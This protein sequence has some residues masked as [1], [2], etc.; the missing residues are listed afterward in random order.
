MINQA[1]YQELAE[2]GHFSPDRVAD[3]IAVYALYGD[4]IR[5]EFTK[6]QHLWNAHRIRP[7]KNRPYLV[8]GKPSAIYFDRRRPTFGI[9][10]GAGSPEQDLIR[11]ML[12]PLD[13]VN[14]DD[15]LT[16]TTAAWCQA[17]LTELGFDPTLQT[18]EDRRRPYFNFYIQLK[19]RI[20]QHLDSGREP[21][22]GMIEAPRGGVEHYVCD[23]LRRMEGYTS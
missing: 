7:Q 21:V 6:F 8:S 22:L 14:V 15:F 12:A 23:H 11:T 19:G 3:Q 13:E 2:L 20:Q 18:E 5:D 9:G 4:M 10:V 16:P 17:Q 1:F